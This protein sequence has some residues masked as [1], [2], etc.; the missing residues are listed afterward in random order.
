MQRFSKAVLA[1]AV[2]GTSALS[3]NSFAGWSNETLGGTNTRVYTPST[4]SSIGSQRGLMVVLHGCGQANSVYQ[5]A[6]LEDAAE[7]WGMVIAL[8][9]GNNLGGATG[10]CWQYWS[11]S[12]QAYS[13]T[14][15]DYKVV[16]D[17]TK[18]IRDDASYNV[19]PD[20]VYVAGL[21]SGAAFANTIAC[22]APDLYAGMGIA[23]GPSI[24]TTD[25]GALYSF[26]SA[27]VAGR[28]VGY[29]GSYGSFLDTQIASFVHGDADYTVKQ[30]YLDQNVD[31]FADIYG[32]SVT[33]AA[34][35]ITVDGKSITETIYGNGRIVRH[36]MAGVGHEWPGGAGASGSY[37]TANS[38]N[39]GNMLAEYFVNNNLRAEG[40]TGGG[41]TGGGDT[42]GGDTGGGDTGGG[43]TG[44]SSACESHTGTGDQ[45]AAL[46]L[47]RIDYNVLAYS[48]GDNVYLGI[49]TATAT[50]YEGPDGL[51]HM[52]DLGNCGGSDGGDTGG[53]DTGGGGSV[54]VG[55][56]TDYRMNAKSY[57]GSKARDY[58][59]YV[60]ASY[61]PANPVPMIM[62]LH[63]CAMDNQG[64]ADAYNF[65]RIA[66]ENNVI[67]VFPF[68]T[69]YDGQRSENCWGYW[70]DNEIHEGAGEV[71]DLRSLAMEVESNYSIDA[72]RRYL[73]GLSSG[74]AMT[75]IGAIAHN[76]YWAAA[77]AARALPY[78][79]GST[80]VTSDLFLN[81]AS[82]FANKIT[83]ELDDSRKIPM[84]VI[85]STNDTVVMHQAAE[86]IRD[87]YI[88]AFGID[89]QADG[90]AVDCTEDGI[91]CIEESYNDANGNEVLR[92]HFIDGDTVGPREGSLG[93]GHYWSGEDYN[94]DAWAW[95]KGPSDTDA[96]W[97]FFKDKT[98]DGSAVVLDADGDG[99]EDSVDNCPNDA[100]ADQA[101]SNG[102]G[103]GDVCDTSG[104][105]DTDNDGVEDSADNCPNTANA[106]QLDS[107]SNGVGD[108]CEA[109]AADADS[110]GV[111]DSADN[112]PNDAN[113]DQLDNDND[114]LGNVCD[115]TPNGPD[116]D[117]DGVTDAADNCPNTANA[118]QLDN[119]NDGLGNACDATP[120]GE[121]TFACTEINDS[122]YDHVQAGRATTDGIYAYA[123]GS[124]TQMGMNNLFYTSTL[125]ETAEGHYELGNCP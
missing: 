20:Q 70:F 24:G 84:L 105:I 11:N 104:I 36:K 54:D 99:V 37:I 40:G 77:A 69:T 52:T 113:A 1:L 23:A 53:G 93:V 6:N 26:E 63:G 9:Q 89:G 106:D 66:D 122:N 74:G 114:G 65:D 45:L 39:Y 28:C 34:T 68:I 33:S 102:N 91:S 59:V 18:E 4:A 14:T 88:Q 100:N 51:G 85:S 110:D 75:V 118:D 95:N 87:S 27:D 12:G 44:G 112:C 90:A 73:T 111:A 60:P 109:G 47:A 3:A 57:S 31:G 107:D 94:Y 81:D 13:R 67:I 7:N 71:E 42:G 25:G 29:A 2:A 43:D 123:V 22:L 50:V 103:T 79:D 16:M 72:N 80:S 5:N 61:N 116:A 98:F 10:D 92:T 78:G 38:A 125:A 108:A 21:S 83:A 55:T 17:L 117:S 19:D 119:D 58:S 35:N 49:N 62:A 48:S 86:L 76:E 124:G 101:D 46:G 96:V 56:Y 32:V 97:D 41:D 15:G 30:E 115:A 121:P 8:P 120:D 64:V 82:Y